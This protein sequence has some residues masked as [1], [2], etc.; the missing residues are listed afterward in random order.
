MIS[1]IRERSKH[2]Q[3]ERLVKDMKV[4]TNPRMFL[5]LATSC[6]KPPSGT[7]SVRKVCKQAKSIIRATNRYMMELGSSATT[8]DGCRL[9][10]QRAHC[11]ARLEAA[12]V[13]GR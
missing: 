1:E 10:C 7:E 5:R 6:T 12:A 9:L 2:V 11:A 3:T 13:D 4:Q 8:K